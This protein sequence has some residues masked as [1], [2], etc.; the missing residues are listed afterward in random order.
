MQTIFEKSTPGRKGVTLPK[1]DDP[2]AIPDRYRRTQPLNLCE[3]SEPDVVRH[4]TALSRMNFGVDDNLYPLGSCTM[5]Y[6]PKACERI[7]ALS[8]FSSIHPMTAQLSGGH[9]RVQG[10]LAV[11]HGLERLLCSVTGMDAFTLQ[12]LAGAHGELTG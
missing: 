10:A 9:K 7:A 11:V 3:L 2:I 5:K 6:N 1:H 8:G 12:P 4:F